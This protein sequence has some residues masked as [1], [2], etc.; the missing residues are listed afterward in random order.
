MSAPEMVSPDLAATQ[1]QHH[2]CHMADDSTTLHSAALIGLP[3]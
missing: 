3:I 1:T 2:A